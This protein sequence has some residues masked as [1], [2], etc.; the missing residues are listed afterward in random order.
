MKREPL[1]LEIYSGMG[2]IIISLKEISIL[3]S[4]L[5]YSMIGY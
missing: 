4:N 2:D 3:I 1:N 5:R